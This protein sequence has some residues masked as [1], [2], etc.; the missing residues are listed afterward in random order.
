MRRAQIL[1][2]SGRLAQAKAAIQQAL[3]LLDGQ[4]PRSPRRA[5]ALRIARI[6]TTDGQSN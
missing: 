6:V 2:A 1:H 4:H 3:P 5:E